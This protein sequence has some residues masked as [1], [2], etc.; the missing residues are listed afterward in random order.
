MNQEN[1]EEDISDI[2]EAV[3]RLSERVK[4]ISKRMSD[5]EKDT[6]QMSDF[7]ANADVRI[8]I[9]GSE[10]N[11]LSEDFSGLDRR[12]KAFELN[13]DSR[14]EGW[15]MVINFVIQLVWVSMAAFILTKLGLQAPL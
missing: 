15:K 7:R 10:L 14:K 2:Q 13:N 4:T 11:Q 6:R 9:L 8:E 1:M 3:T 5:F 12:M